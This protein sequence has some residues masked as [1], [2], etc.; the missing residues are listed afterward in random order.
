MAV[1]ATIFKIDLEIAD[2]DRGYYGSH[3]LTIAR[4]PSET[5][6]RMMI[7]VLAF[8]LCAHERL[9]FGTGI[10][11]ADEPDLWRR[12]LTGDIEQW[13][14]VGQPDPRRI[15]KGCGRAG[16]VSVYLYGGRKAATWWEQERA[17]LERHSNLTVTMLE[18]EQTAKLAD[19]AGRGI[20]IQC[21]IQD[22]AVWMM[23]DSMSVEITPVVLLRAGDGRRGAVPTRGASGP[24]L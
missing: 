24:G 20:S 2:M 11:T 23:R 3:A 14:E 1:K 12:S 8:A 7:R 18:P 19:L 21:N 9:E 22:G 13:I 17:G 16:S 6:E 10:S 5:S 15:H 4:H